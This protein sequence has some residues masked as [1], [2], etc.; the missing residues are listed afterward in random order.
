MLRGYLHAGL[1]K[2]HLGLPRGDDVWR[3]RTLRHPSRG[4]VGWMSG[5][6][7]PALLA[8]RASPALGRCLFAPPRGAIALRLIELDGEAL[9][10]P[11]MDRDPVND[12]ARH[13]LI[14]EANE[15]RG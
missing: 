7:R 6:P 2:R 1:L 12:H 10:V 8:Y 14:D 15:A 4:D 13:V 9:A 5:V 3:I 11:I